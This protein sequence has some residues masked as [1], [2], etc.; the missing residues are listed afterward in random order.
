[1]TVSKTT[2]RSRFALSS[3]LA[4]ATALVIGA[5]NPARAQSFNGSGTVTAGSASIGTGTGTTDVFV[6]G[7]AVID[8]SPTDT[9]GGTAPIIF[10]NSGTTATFSGI[11]NFTVLNRIL[12][13]T[14]TRA[15]QFDGTVLGRIGA[16]APSVGGTVYFYSPGG[17][18]AG[19][20]SVFDVGNLGLTSSPVAYD[21]ATG[22]FDAGNAVSF[23]AANAG[24]SVTVAS[25]AQLTASGYLALVAPV[26]VNDGTITSTAGA[27]AG[28]GVAM[29]AAN[30]ADITFSPDGLFNIAVTQGTAATGTVLSNSGSVGGTTGGT[31]GTASHRVYMVAIPQN[32]AITMAIASGSSLGFDIAGAASVDGNAVVLSGGYN[33]LAGEA[34]VSPVAAGGTVAISMINTDATSRLSARASDS[35]VIVASGGVSNFASNVTLLSV[36]SSA[37][38]ANGVNSS[39]NVAGALEVSSI[40][41]HTFAAAG[42]N[43]TGGI[44]QVRAQNSGTVDV[45]GAF[46]MTANG[47]GGDA[48]TGTTGSG[49]GGSLLVQASLGGTIRLRGAAGF[50]ADGYSGFA[51]GANVSSGNATGGSIDINAFG[52]GSVVQFD[53]VATID[54]RGFGGNAFGTGTAGAVQ[55]GQINITATGGTGNAVTFAQN[56]TIYAD[57]LAGASENGGSN[58]TGGLIRATADSAGSIQFTSANT[59]Q[60]LGIGGDTTVGTGG[61]GTGGTIEA[62]SSGTANIGFGNLTTL[63]ARGTGGVTSGAAAG[64]AGTGG[65]ARLVANGGTIDFARGNIDANGD[66]GVGQTGGAGTG[67]TASLIASASGAINLTGNIGPAGLPTGATTLSSNGAGAGT[68]A[69]T[70]GTGGVGTGGNSVVQA[71]TGGS[72]TSIFSLFVDAN[73]SGG[74]SRGANVAAASGLGGQARVLGSSGASLNFANL[75]MQASAR[76]S[77]GDNLT[78][79]GIGGAGTGGTAEISIDAATYNGGGSFS[80]DSSGDGGF[81]DLAGG[82]GLGGMSLAGF[83]NGASVTGSSLTL[84]SGSSG[85]DGF[86]GGAGTGGSSLL[87]ITN[88]TAGFATGIVLDASG[89]GGSYFSLTGSGSGGAGVGGTAQ[90]TVNETV[91]SVASLN[92]GAALAIRANGF[93]G[94]AQNGGIGQ[95]GNAGLVANAGDVSASG[96]L[97]LSALGDGGTAIDTGSGTPGFGGSG[98]GGNATVLAQAGGGLSALDQLIIDTT[99]T[100]GNSDG[101]QGSGGL[102]QGG[103]ANVAASSGAITVSSL[104]NVDA[105]GIGGDGASGAGANGGAAILQ[106][107]GT[108]TFTL[109]NPDADVAIYA[110]ALSGQ[111]LVAGGT[112]GNAFG[113]NAQ[114]VATGGAIAITA[115]TVRVDSNGAQNGGGITGTDGGNGRGGTASI[116]QNGSGSIAITADAISVITTGTGADNLGGGDLIAGSGTGGDAR[117]AVNSAAGISLTGFV[118]VVADGIGGDGSASSGSSSGGNATG[119][120]A[121]IGAVNG[122]NSVN[123]QSFVYARAFGGSAQVDGNGGNAIGGQAL[124]GVVAGATAGS[125]TF[126]STVTSSIVAAYATGGDALGAGLGG[127][128]VGGTAQV[129]AVGGNVTANGLLSLNA[130]GIGGSSVDG[131][132]GDGTGGFSSLLA[133]GRTLTL[134]ETA[135]LLAYGSG[136]I[137][138]GNGNG[139]AGTGGTGSIVAQNGATI[140]AGDSLFFNIRGDGGNATGL[141]GDGGTGDG[142]DALIRVSGGSLLDVTDTTQLDGGARGGAHVFS[143]TGSPSGNGAS[144]LGGTAVIEV[145]DT[146]TLNF[147]VD[148][149]LAADASGGNSAFT[150][151]VPSLTGGGATGGT[152]RLS[153]A[154]GT[155]TIGG[156]ATVTANAIGG[157]GNAAGGNADGGFAL[158]D[159]LAGQITVARDTQVFADASGGVS[160]AGG[161]GATGGSATGGLTRISIDT[162]S[163]TFNG[164][165]RV[166]AFGNGG[167][168]DTIAPGNGG[169]GTGGQAIVETTGAG[170]LTFTATGTL[171]GGPTGPGA[172]QGLYLVTQGGGGFGFGTGFSTGAGTGG[173]STLSASGGGTIAVAGYTQVAAN[174]LG[175]NS[176]DGA[177]GADVGGVGQGGDALVLALDGTVS[178][179]RLDLQAVGFGGDARGVAGSGTG[180]NATI[181]AANAGT[182]TSR[183]TTGIIN[184]FA[185]GQGGNGTAGRTPADVGGIGGNGTG[186][187]LVIAAAS[188]SGDLTT[189]A[190]NAQSYGLGGIG[191]NGVDNAAGLGGNGGAGGTGTGGLVNIGSISGNASTT[192]ANGTATY[193]SIQ[194]SAQGTGGAGG[195]G[196]TGLTQGNG[197]NGGAAFDGS[198]VL[199]VRGSNVTVTGTT[200][201]SANATGGNG[202]AGAVAGI[203]GDAT[204]GEGG[205]IGVTV[206]N[207]FQVQAQRG[208]L[209]AGDILGTANATGGTGSVDGQAIV[210]ATP[211]RILIDHADATIG[212]VDLSSNGTTVLSGAAPSFVSLLGGSATIAGRFGFATAGDVT[213]SLDG[214][215]LVADNA[216]IFGSNWVL[217]TAPA[218]A[219]T[220]RVNTGLGLGTSL[221]LVTFANIAVNA[222]TAFVVPGDLQ[223]GNLSGPSD[224]IAQ[225]G[226]SITLGAINAGGSIDLLAGGNITTLGQTSGAFIDMLSSGGTIQTGSLFALQSID[227]SSFGGGTTVSGDA[228]AGDTVVV[229]ANGDIVIGNVSAGI[230]NPSSDPLATYRVGLAAAGSVT[231]GNISAQGDVGLL[232]DAGAVQ[233]GTLSG[234]DMLVLASTGASVS[235]LSSTGR[236]LFADASMAALGGAFDTFDVNPVFAAAPVAM[237]GSITLG[238]PASATDFLSAYTNGNFTAGGSLTTGTSLTVQTGGALTMT[239]GSINGGA[240]SLQSTGSMTLRDV[241]SN[242]AITLVSLQQGGLTAGN[243]TAAGN[244]V[245]FSGGDFSAENIVSDAAL[246]GVASTSNAVSIGAGGT[247]LA[248]NI[249]STENIVLSGT[250][251]SVGAVDGR[252]QV[253]LLAVDQLSAGSVLSASG[254]VLIGG[255]A[256]LQGAGTIFNIDYAALFAN[257]PAQTTGAVTIG[258]AVS[259]RNIDVHAGGNFT[260]TGANATG[261]LNVDAGGLVNLGGDIAVSD[262]VTVQSGGNLVLGNISAGIVNPSSDPLATFR[263]GLSASGNVTT[264]T[265][266]A[267][268][269]IGLLAAG[270]AVQTGALQGRDMLVLASTAASVGGFT[271]T[272]RVLFADASMAALGGAFETFNVNPVFAATPVA[273]AGPILIEGTGSATNFLSAHTSGNFTATGALSGGSRVNLQIGGT[274]TATGGTLTGGVVT[275]QSGG[276]M[277]LANVSSNRFVILSS[278]TGVSTG[279]ITAADRVFIGSQGN[280]TTGNIVSDPNVFNAGSLAN[281]V[282]I[283]AGGTIT[284]GNIR[285][286]QNIALAGRNINSG[287]LN[288]RFQVALLAVDQITSGSVLAGAVFS[289]TGQLVGANG[290]VLIGNPSMLQNAGGIFNLDYAKLFTGPFVPTGGSVTINGSIIARNIGALAGGDFTASG[291]A[292]F[293]TLDVISGGLVTVRGRWFS[294]DMVIESN[295]IAILP[296][297]QSP[298]NPGALSGLNAGTTGQITL[299]S[300]NARGAFI[301]DG[302]TGNGYGL[303]QAEISL[304]NSGSLNVFAID[305]TGNLI[306]MTI[307]DLAMTGPQAGSTIDDPNG[308]IRFATGTRDDAG[309]GTPSGGIRIVGNVSARGLLSTNRVE[310]LADL[311]ELDAATGS[312]RVTGSGTALGGEISIEAAHIHIA[313]GEIL[314]RLEQDP[315][316]AGRIADLN[317]PAAVSRPE[318]VISAGFIDLYPAQTLYI[319]NTG[320]RET[321]AG[322]LAADVD[323]TPP[324]VPPAGGVQAVVNGQFVTDAGVLTGKAAYDALIAAGADFTGFSTE[325]QLNSC[326]FTGGCLTGA[327]QDPVRGISSEIQMVTGPVLGDTPEMVAAQGGTGSDEEEEEQQT[328]GAEAAVAAAKAATEAAAESSASSPIAPPAPLVDTRPLTPPG[329]VTQPV[330]GSGNPALIGSAVNESTAQGDAQ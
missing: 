135:G 302:L 230:V 117:I 24:S 136:G 154:N 36:N 92:S 285:S 35:A 123:G 142:G 22:V 49:T 179:N 222:P 55:G 76:G 320:T 325:G 5:A 122:A 77:G 301:G 67:G 168:S 184:A 225:A 66:G 312:L 85:G 6:N 159:A 104:V 31:A 321:P 107:T 15:V 269:D 98:L 300:T 290:A 90:I 61:S 226:G 221:D 38:T 262:S 178:T 173:E 120:L 62:L 43:V 192:A 243:I 266:A 305:Q 30:A 54:A 244:I 180:G 283:G 118:E 146:G 234:R 205:G 203:G 182:A 86:N 185:A 133:N 171:A 138:T 292:G 125:I 156:A 204:V 126:G 58:A 188:G 70:T 64:G 109:N 293:S 268:G 289:P 288:A 33:I 236:V 102:G 81:G 73:G 322:F 240:V 274:L 330:T 280:V 84:D 3:T 160:I 4:M 11:S 69:N 141:L 227:L 308:V 21:V 214:G 12:P 14:A 74:D 108:G 57:A 216:D 303:S 212:S 155:V 309:N 63:F 116:S 217:G 270:G 39:V 273:M 194:M 223:F 297:Q 174:G 148:V 276:A 137:S 93:G 272:G 295:D 177:F 75:G 206:T 199:L 324:D 119:G 306:D 13:S 131:T 210:G 271:S 68:N 317:A 250:N 299:I 278:Q 37:L 169:A 114:I 143:G 186:G 79:S 298:T 267:R 253:A 228:D 7:N 219:G 277:A 279:N 311:F 291:I 144:A 162:G 149:T 105:G 60:A 255:S 140:N 256:M 163:M 94:D 34:A 87:T 47:F 265:I 229:Q 106:T 88:S 315:L 254:D 80:I 237:T 175:G 157:F 165:V 166:A 65:A 246:F 44:A 52:N 42:A 201:L 145:I 134:G 284:T 190:V 241:S 249:R 99:G 10:Q 281:S 167:R 207:R 51:S 224:L 193:A 153:A 326:L 296:A 72:I 9:A 151:V 209:I 20:S 164:N 328:Q 257:A 48:S 287:V 2:R 238:G 101:A 198:A 78:A 132:A 187:T 304:I 8:W 197:G 97:F 264:G 128:A 18:I 95:G 235:G 17:I 41:P 314:S 263:V 19:A 129:F 248:E 170:S 50:S 232:A 275:L 252:L 124:V 127:D 286:V 313:D 111:A 176:S 208:T 26:V 239:A 40:D 218:S 329:D 307:G 191:G 318:G 196:G 112:G 130:Y 327:E 215:D 56:V 46:Q 158:I 139:G 245:V 23:G 16:S 189:G 82:A 100:G 115:G 152:S 96:T 71:D 147:G 59:F 220:L 172:P 29:V 251:V 202:G 310:F 195:N 242:R 32:Q 27:N 258:G 282:Q 319:Q 25:G 103:S 150:N 53:R 121:N 211:V 181:E 294:P 183:I 45:T 113:G 247:L 28:G 261:S 233:A 213:L 260:A 316:Y 161:A 1:M 91:P 110:R 259:G 231:A 323:A 200:N 83:F 89:T